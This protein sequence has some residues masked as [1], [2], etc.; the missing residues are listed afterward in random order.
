MSRETK[1]DVRCIYYEDISQIPRLGVQ[2]CG[3]ARVKRRET[4]RIHCH[5]SENPTILHLKLGLATIRR[6]HELNLL[7]RLS[8]RPAVKKAAQN[9]REMTP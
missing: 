2:I 7:T 1:V 5:E 4:N 9:T 8:P 6:R 3:K